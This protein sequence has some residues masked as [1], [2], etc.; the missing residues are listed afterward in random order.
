MPALMRLED[1]LEKCQMPVRPQTAKSLKDFMLLES[2]KDGVGKL[3]KPGQPVRVVV[4]SGDTPG[5]CSL[6]SW[7][8]YSIR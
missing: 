5:E 1:D 8:E 3:W 4:E 6:S 2:G 7:H